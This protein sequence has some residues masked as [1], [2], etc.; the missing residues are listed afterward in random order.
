MSVGDGVVPT[1]NRGCLLLRDSVM[2]KTFKDDRNIGGRG[3]NK[4]VK[5]SSREFV[6]WPENDDGFDE[7]DSKLNRYLKREKDRKTKHQEVDED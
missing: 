2:G 5:R 4:G 1:P 6:F 3:F 7:N